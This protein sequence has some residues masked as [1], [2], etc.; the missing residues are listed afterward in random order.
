V[1]GGA[2]TAIWRV[3]RGGEVYALR[4]FRP[5]ETARCGREVEAMTA[6]RIGGV[7]T[8]EVIADGVYEERPVLLLSWIKGK[9][10]GQ[11][12]QEISEPEK[13]ATAFGR[14]QAA[15]HALPPPPEFDAYR[16]IEWAGEDEAELKA[17]LREIQREKPALLHLD[18]H[19]LNV[20][21]DENGITGV[22]DWANTAAGDPRADFARTYSILRIEPWQADGDDKQWESLRQR[23]ENAWRAGYESAGGNTD[24][25]ALFYAWAGAVMVRDLSP[26][27]GKPGFWLQDHHLDVVRRWRDEQKQR[28]GI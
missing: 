21:G 23:L 17:R 6:A 19:P 13:L 3:E 14:T 22:I 5:E 1:Q 25:M 10:L 28:A 15:I 2:D 26:R 18:Y 8:P 24:D 20:M 4:V 11:L 16:W 7:P 27:V 12:L 9:A